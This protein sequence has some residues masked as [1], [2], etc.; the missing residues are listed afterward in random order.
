[1]A[2]DVAWFGIDEM[3]ALGFDHNDI[4]SAAI[5]RLKAKILYDA[6]GFGLLDE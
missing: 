2:N 1:M 4:L 5:K 3:H 6:V